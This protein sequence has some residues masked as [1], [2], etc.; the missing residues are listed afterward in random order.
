M[1][2]SVGAGFPSTGIQKGHLFHD[3]DNST[4]WVFLGGTSPQS[5]ANWKLLDGVVTAQPDTSL[6][7]LSQAGASCNRRIRIT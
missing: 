5:V 2:D 3:L 7:G 6:W 4:L 1:A